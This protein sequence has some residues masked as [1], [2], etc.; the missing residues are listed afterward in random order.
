[1]DDSSLQMEMARIK[2]SIAAK[3]A[4]QDV[5]SFTLHLSSYHV[6]TV[7]VEHCVAKR[8]STTLKGSPQKYLDLQ[9]R[10]ADLVADSVFRGNCQ[11]NHLV[12]EREHRSEPPPVAEPGRRLT[13][14]EVAASVY[15]R[16]G[17]FEVTVTLQD[18]RSGVTHG[19]ALLYSKLKTQKFPKCDNIL[20]RMERKLSEYVGDNVDDETDMQQHSQ[21][22]VLEPP[23]SEPKAPEI[24]INSAPAP[25]VLED[26]IAT[27]APAEAKLNEASLVAAPVSQAP[28]STQPDPSSNELPASTDRASCTD[29]ESSSGVAAKEEEGHETSSAEVELASADKEQSS[30]AKS[31]A[32]AEDDLF[33]P[34]VVNGEISDFYTKS[35]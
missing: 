17:A 3:H 2:E 6:L 13:P 26:P 12:N 8:P 4:L 1:M 9:N 15:P 32:P 23:T 21:M 31:S 24:V 11:L 14:N 18:T 10:L 33:P 20:E 34:I 5:G 30:T 27:K 29:Q 16:I 25:N 35:S 28:M 7:H 22:N 19:P